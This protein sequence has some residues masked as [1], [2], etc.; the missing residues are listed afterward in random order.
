MERIFLVG[1]ASL[2]PIP[3]PSCFSRHVSEAERSFKPCSPRPHPRPA[4][5]QRR[6]VTPRDLPGAKRD[7]A[8]AWRNP[9][10]GP[11]ADS[12]EA[13]VLTAR[14]VRIAHAKHAISES[15]GTEVVNE[16]DHYDGLKI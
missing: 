16:I 14:V 15:S 1:V 13:G 2:G 5:V 11:L 12:F 7:A 6:R 9:D 4:T 3:F 8:G 10:I